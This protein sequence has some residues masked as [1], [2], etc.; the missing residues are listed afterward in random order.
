MECTLHQLGIPCDYNVSLEF[1]VPTNDTSSRSHWGEGCYK[2]E[3]APVHLLHMIC[4]RHPNQTTHCI[5]RLQSE[6]EK[7]QFLCHCSQ[8]E[9]EDSENLNKAMPDCKQVVCSVVWK[10]LYLVV[11]QD[12]LGKADQSMTDV[13]WKSRYTVLGRALG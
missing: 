7:E 9:Y 6:P 4:H 8:L 1:Q 10:G 11:S 2:F 5:P 12:T 3:F 13:E